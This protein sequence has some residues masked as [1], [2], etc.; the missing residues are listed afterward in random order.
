MIIEVKNGTYSKYGLDPEISN[1]VKT[2]VETVSSQ[3]F[4]FLNGKEIYGFEINC[5]KTTIRMIYK[6]DS[7]ICKNN[8]LSTSLRV[9][10][11][12]SY[13]I[14]LD[15]KKPQVSEGLV[16]E[17]CNKIL[18]D[19]DG[20]ICYGTFFSEDQERTLSLKSTFKLLCSC[21]FPV[22]AGVENIEKNTILKSYVKI[23]DNL[24][25][26]YGCDKIKFV[27]PSNNVYMIKGDGIYADALNFFNS[28]SSIYDAVMGLYEDFELEHEGEFLLI[29]EELSFRNNSI[30]VHDIPPILSMIKPNEDILETIKNFLQL[31]ATK[32]ENWKREREEEKQKKVQENKTRREILMGQPECVDIYRLVLDS[33]GLTESSIVNHLKGTKTN[34][35]ITHPE[36]YGKWAHHTRKIL[37]GFVNEMISADFFSAEEKYYTYGSFIVLRIKNEVSMHE[38]ECK[39]EA[40]CS[41]EYID[42][43]EMP[44]IKIL[45]QISS[46]CQEVVNGQHALKSLCTLFSSCQ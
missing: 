12:M 22:V 15:G 36:L 39:K 17:I 28:D 29:D 20:R 30:V 27:S 45:Q 43:E 46:L 1:A 44:N 16:D 21:N 18:T 24:D 19:L 10:D 38:A 42:E 41:E 33:D 9:N 8:E 25:I 31:L 11:Y 13:N 23:S 7:F 32:I 6:G 14:E 40:S 26:S 5:L 2:V 3:V 34:E 37:K 4:K 35:Y